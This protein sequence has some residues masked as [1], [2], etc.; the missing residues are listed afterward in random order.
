MHI[1]TAKHILN[2]LAFSFLGL[3]EFNEPKSTDFFGP[4]KGAG[5]RTNRTS[6]VVGSWD[7]SAGTVREPGCHLLKGSRKREKNVGQPRG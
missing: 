1:N 4:K 5:S 7:F 2:Y 6:F 3:P